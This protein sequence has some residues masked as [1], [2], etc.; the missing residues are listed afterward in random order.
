M[1]RLFHVA[2]HNIHILKIKLSSILSLSIIAFH[3]Q[4]NGEFIKF[5]KA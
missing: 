2:V 5:R 1:L 4:F 3:A